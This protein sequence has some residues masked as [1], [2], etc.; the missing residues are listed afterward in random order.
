MGIFANSKMEFE[1]IPVQRL[2][3]VNFRFY[4]SKEIKSLSVK[5]ITNSQTFDTLLHPTAGGLYD[6]ALG[7]VDKD[8]LCGTCGQNFVH[9][10]G[11]MGHI[12]LPLPVYNPVYFKTMFKILRGTCFLCHRLMVPTIS[13]HVFIKKMDLL[14]H[15]L[16]PSVGQLDEFAKNLLQETSQNAETEESIIQQITDMATTLLADESLQVLNAKNLEAAKTTVIQD[17]IAA[18]F[19]TTGKCPHCKQRKKQIRQ[20]YNSKILLQGRKSTLTKS[21]EKNKERKKEQQSQSDF[22]KS[23]EGE[24]M[25]DDNS[26]NGMETEESVLP[27][28]SDTQTTTSDTQN[29]ELATQNKSEQVILTAQQIRQH[30]RQVWDYDSPVLKR[31]YGSLSKTS[32]DHPTDIFFL[33]IVPV[34]PS[35][36]RPIA[37]MKDKKFENAQTANL[38]RLLVDSAAIRQLIEQIGK[39]TTSEDSVLPTVLSQVIGS[40][41]HEKL[42]NAWVQ[43]QTHV[44]CVVDSDLDKISPEKHPGIKQLLEKKEGLFRKHMM[45]KR[46]NYAARS[47]ISPDPCISTN[48]IGIP[49]VF[50]KKL[51]YPQPV[52]PWNIQELRQ[53]VINGPEIH[54]GASFVVNEDGSKVLLNAKSLTQREAIAK[55]LLTPSTNPLAY[56]ECK[57]VYRHLKNGD[58][59]LLNRQ[60]TLHRPSIQAHKARVLPGEKTLRMHYANCKAYNADFDGDEMNAHFPQNELA[61]AEAYTI[62][63]TDYQYLVPKDGSPLAGLIQDHMVAG[64]SLTMRGRFFNRQD[65]CQ[66]VNTALQD[67]RGV[68][69]TLQP[70]IVKPCPLWTGKQVLSTVLLNNIPEGKLPLN[71]TG[72]A[73]IPEKSWSRGHSPSKHWMGVDFLKNS[74]YMGESTVIIREGELL[75]GVLD[76]GHYGPTPYGLVHCCYELYGGNVAGRLLTCLGRLFMIFLQLR[77]FTL[78]VEDI[79]VTSQANRSRDTAVGASKQC[80]PQSTAEALGVDDA[81]D[82]EALVTAFKQAHFSSDDQQLKEMDLSMKSRTDDIQNEIARA[83][84]PKGLHKLFPDNN[85]QLMVQSGAKGSTVNCMQISCLLGQI[86]LEGRRPPLMLSGKSLPSFLPY[87]SSP[88]AGGFVTGRFLTGIRPQEYFFH[89]MAGREGLIDTA[90]K[91]SRSGYL[92]RCLIKHL[93]GIM[94]NYDL[95][96]RDSDGSIIQFYYGEDGMDISKTCFLKPKQFPFLLENNKVTDKDIDRK[97][98]WEVPQKDVKKWNN[99]IAKWRKRNKGSDIKSRRSGFLSYCNSKCLDFSESE[100]LEMT[101]IGRSVSACKQCQAWQDLSKKAKNKYSKYRGRCPDPII[102]KYRPYQ[103]NRVL[104]EKISSII[105]SYAKKELSQ[106]SPLEPEQF[107]CFMNTKLLKSMSEPGEAVGLLCSQSIGEPSTQMTL[108]TFHFAG[109]G[110]MNVTLGIPRL[111][112]IL[113]VGSAN[114]KTPTMEIPVLNTEYARSKV[115][116]L[117]LKLNRVKLSE[118]LTEVMVSEYLSIQEQMKM[119]RSRMFKIRFEFLSLHLYKDRLCVTP[120]SILKYMETVYFKHLISKIMHKMQDLSNARLLT[121]GTMRE[122]VPVEMPST[123]DIVDENEE[124][125]FSDLEQDDGN[126]AAVKERQKLEEEQEYEGDENDQDQGESQDVEDDVA[127]D[128]RQEEEDERY[129]EVQI[130]DDADI[131]S[132]I[133]TAEEQKNKENARINEIY[134]YCDILDTKQLYCNDI[135][136]MASMYGIE[137]ANKVIIKEIQNVFAAYGIEVDYRHLSLLADY[138]TFEGS[139]K[140][141]NRMSMDTCPSPFQKMTFE[142]T[143][144]FLIN[145]SIQGSSDQLKNPSSRLV[146]G[147]VVSCGSGAMDI[148]QPLV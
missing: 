134:K 141:F 89:C 9:C 82:K 25:E 109:R 35:R 93:E 124:E 24:D 50:A 121:S 137:A 6:A 78:G 15:G 145:A 59:L 83:C 73:K 119:K 143:M 68:I 70:A 46:V 45:G 1:E 81:E 38:C 123:Q 99:R 32:S 67:H 138:M 142:T 76:K 87:D 33:E 113:M 10:P 128:D 29:S 18:H 3:S 53:A 104:P 66:L 62:S 103:Q 71:L 111:R 8:D 54:P 140:P 136:A 72:K 27:D 106:N 36:F 118:V 37:R 51:T 131:I 60:P 4:S 13:A 64:V 75:C 11:H 12:V 58:I 65:Y 148:L 147:R 80:G 92:Q 90:V 47:V 130:E 88:R 139:Y 77:G 110:E 43:L 2:H 57:K 105:H 91:T 52:T 129:E 49:Q 42:Q 96:V 100:K 127:I 55:Q 61:R 117:Q 7:P 107:E 14:D 22:I 120:G 16:I 115:K 133:L 63:S 40:T 69:H 126:A 132:Q 108:N 101:N 135:H 30:L 39:D 146:V 94:V 20:E 74:D 17:T 21:N 98:S 84:M 31:L 34:P 144:Q 125:Y 26:E 79:L 85:L 19:T 86:E 56:R 114:I 5:E 23:G 116:E 41:I 102:S 44:N 97:Q 95:T 28:P 48:E 112:E 122:R